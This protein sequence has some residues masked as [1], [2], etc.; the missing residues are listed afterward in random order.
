MR[1]LVVDDDR[2]DHLMAERAIRTCAADAVIDHAYGAD[3]AIRALAGAV[4]DLVVVDQHMPCRGG[5]E[6]LSDLRGLGTAGKTAFVMLTSDHGDRA[7]ANALAA[8]F[9]AFLCKPIGLQRMQEIV[10]GSRRFWELSELPV[11]MSYYYEKRRREG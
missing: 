7:R 4:Y 1:I 8:E 3:D 2:M 10:D 5:A 6:L 11:D 9:D